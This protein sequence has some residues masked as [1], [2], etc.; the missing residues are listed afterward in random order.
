MP[1]GMPSDFRFD[2]HAR[3]RSGPAW[4]GVENSIQ[5]TQR[6][7]GGL[8]RAAG[9]LLGIGGVVSGA[10]L[11][12]LVRESLSAA[13]AVQD[14]ADRAG[15]SA[16]FLQE[17]RYAASQSGA[18][19]R[20]F[21]DS[22]SRLNRRLGLFQ[23]HLASGTGEAGPAAQAFRAL[24]LEGRIASG[25]LADAESVFREVVRALSDMESE[26]RRS[27]L[28]SQLFGEDSGP[29]LASMLARG[30][31]GISS[32]TARARELGLVLTDEMIAKGA[33]ASDQMETLGM[34][35]RTNVQGAIIDNADDIGEL[36]EAFTDALPGMIE[37]A[38]QLA[39]QIARW[40]G[41]SDADPASRLEAQAR[42]TQVGVLAG[43]LS[44]RLGTGERLHRG[45]L[46]DVRERFMSLMGRDALGDINEQVMASDTPGIGLGPGRS[47]LG[48]SNGNAERLQVSLMLE[49]LRDEAERVRNLKSGFEQ[50][51]DALGQQ[52][53]LGDDPARGGASQLAKTPRDLLDATATGMDDPSK[54]QTAQE[55]ARI[56]SQAKAAALSEEKRA[57]IELGQ[58]QATAY[59]EQLAED[60]GAFMDEF[61]SVFAGGAMA[62]W[63]GKLQEFLI[64]RLREAAFEGLYDAFRN[65]AGSMFDSMGD[66]KGGGLVGSVLGLFGFG[67]KRAAGGPAR[68][69]MAYQWQEQGR[70]FFSPS[71]PGEVIRASDMG[72]EIIR[73]RVVV[74]RVDKSDLFETAVQEAA[75]PVA[76]QAAQGAVQQ[77]RADMAGAQ[78]R[79]SKRL[80]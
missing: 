73:E 74:V 16:E 37:L 24:G 80:R 59:K 46:S 30:E 32:L 8:L 78:M 42:L 72:R 53:N 62:A 64:G 55:L 25:E 34:V 63:D 2:I 51:G 44:Q 52:T 58:L 68:P 26:S 1:L 79:A 11:A 50:A 10:G 43:D 18:E 75:A 23:Q 65:I 77:S 39:D 9:P 49:A 56:E 3:D 19:T 6:A 17:M 76:V 33:E 22:I 61:A 29:R 15:V 31:E 21:D 47:L 5:R 14:L 7:V 60:R 40:A 54:T 13:E 69:G 20:D 35:L 57:A 48:S 41:M 71:V 45:N 12:M 27:A 66:S 36:A 70:E 38:T 67:G 4:R 28:A